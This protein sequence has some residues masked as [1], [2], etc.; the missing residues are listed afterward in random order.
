MREQVS[1]IAIAVREGADAVMLSGETAYGK[2]PRKA[3]GVMGTVAQRTES[4]MLRFSVRALL[5][6]LQPPSW[7]LAHC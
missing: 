7:L 2:F 5:P 6:L 3:L 4:S 1:D